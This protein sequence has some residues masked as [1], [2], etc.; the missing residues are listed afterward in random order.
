MR[1]RTTLAAVACAVGV[2]LSFP[3]SAHAADGAF[4][5][6]TY[7]GQKALVDPPGRECITLP[8]VADWDVPPATH[9]VNDTDASATVFAG[10]DCDGPHFSLPPYAGAALPAGFRSVVFSF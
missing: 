3:V 8:E 4:A 2:A 1:I 6:R 7:Q 10:P 9:A 5:Y